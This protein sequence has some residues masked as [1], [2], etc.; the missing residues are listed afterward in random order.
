MA[1]EPAPILVTGLPRS[2]TSWVGKM[3][4]A[5]GELVYI[6]EPLN[7]Q[8]PPGLSPG[9]LNGPDPVPYQYIDSHNAAQWEKPFRRMLAL[10]YGLLAEIRRNRSPYDIFRIVKYL[11]A[12]N[13]GRLGGRR[14]LVDDPYSLMSVR[15]LTQ[16]LG[17]RAVILVREPRSYVGSRI[18]LGWKAGLEKITAQEELM[19]ALWDGH[20]AVILDALGDSDEVVKT[21]ALWSAAYDAVDRLF[22]P[23]PK[24]R[25]VSYESL[26]SRPVPAFTDLYETLG[27][28]MTDRSRGKI[29]EATTTAARRPRAFRWSGTSRTAFQPMDS[30]ASLESYKRR[31][32]SEQVAA[33]DEVTEDVRSRFYERPPQ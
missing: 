5:S 30:A 7:P 32:S 16:D 33:V 1:D 26:A 14:A 10:R 12:F 23:L 11:Y 21:A 18:K 20:D 24:V 17:M 13:R 19:A 28:T 27:L 3:L 15:W 2:G 25:V 9:V 31:L 4:E 22:R 8:H 29:K 6:N